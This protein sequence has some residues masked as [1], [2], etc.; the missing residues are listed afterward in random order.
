MDVVALIVQID[1][2]LHVN[3][4]P[5]CSDS[6]SDTAGEDGDEDDGHHLVPALGDADD[7][8]DGTNDG[9]DAGND[10]TTDRRFRRHDVPGR[11]GWKIRHV[12]PGHPHLPSLQG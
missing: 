2:E 1:V 4:G 7:H 11:A 8:E 9:Q 6:Q 5:C 10:E 3:H 12:H